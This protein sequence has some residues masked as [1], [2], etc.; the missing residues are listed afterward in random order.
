M[1]ALLKHASPHICYHTYRHKY[2]R[3]PKTGE[4]WN[5]ALLGWEV[6][7]YTKIHNPPHMCYHVRFDSS[8]TNNECT[9]RRKHQKSGSAG[10]LPLGWGRGWPLKT[11]PSLCV[12]HVKFGSSASNGVC[13]NRRNPQNCDRLTLSLAAGAWLTPRN[14]PSPRVIDIMPNLV[15]LG[16]MV[17]YK[18]Y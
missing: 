13:I 11:S 12:N 14:T 18:R 10:P 15:V 17:Q 1:A 9:N 6:W 4:R 3:T 16:Q 2:R 7:R 5:T 8:V